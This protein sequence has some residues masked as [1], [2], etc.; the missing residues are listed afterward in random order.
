MADE[1]PNPHRGEVQ[2]TLGGR[3]MTMRPTMQALAAIENIIGIGVPEMI[4]RFKAGTWR[5]QWVPV[6]I[7]HGLKAGSEPSANVAAVGEMIVEAGALRF[8]QP[9]LQFLMG[10]LVGGMETKPGEEVAA[11]SN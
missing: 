1:T 8:A 5:L 11:E 2:V 7:T 9:I 6:I 4:D 10:A 3:A